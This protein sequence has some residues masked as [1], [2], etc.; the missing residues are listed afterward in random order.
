MTVRRWRASTLKSGV[1]ILTEYE[2]DDVEWERHG[3]SRDYHE[4]REGAISR[5]GE[6]LANRI[7][8]AEA[9]LRNARRLRATLRRGRVFERSL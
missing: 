7:V 4:T 6:V 2:F 1:I 3:G 9:T 8:K 5:L